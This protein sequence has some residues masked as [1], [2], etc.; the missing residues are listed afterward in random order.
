M[1]KWADGKYY[2]GK[3]VNDKREGNGKF[4]WADGRIYEG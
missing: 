2:E 1:L 4:K 3:F